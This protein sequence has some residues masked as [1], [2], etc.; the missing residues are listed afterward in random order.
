MIASEN[1]IWEKTCPKAFQPVNL[2]VKLSLE[3]DHGAGR[4]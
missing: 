4:L 2:R 1:P 3:R